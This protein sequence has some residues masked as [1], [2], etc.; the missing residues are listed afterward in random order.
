MEV[1]LDGAAVPA[2]L[3]LN[4]QVIGILYEFLPLIS[5]KGTSGC[6]LIGCK[7]ICV[8]VHLMR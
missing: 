3:P 5:G 8:T 2:G 6:Q 4:H 7:L 1:G